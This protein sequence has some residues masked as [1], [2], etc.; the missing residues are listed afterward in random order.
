[1]AR[2][3]Q[4]DNQ[5]IV[6]LDVVTKIVILDIQRQV[7]FT[8]GPVENEDYVMWDIKSKEDLAKIVAKLNIEI[9]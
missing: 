5:V 9:I 2:F 6:N 7:F 8:F 3:I 4:Y 1:M